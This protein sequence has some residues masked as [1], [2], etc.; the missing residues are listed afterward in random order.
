MAENGKGTGLWVG[1][2]RPEFGGNEALHS[3][4]DAGINK[5]GLALETRVTNGRNEGILAFESSS[6]GVDIFEIDMG[7]LDGCGKF[8]L[9]GFTGENRYVEFPRVD[10][11]I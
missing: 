9:G 3:G 7:D 1:Q 10:E 8:G 11:G 2:V 6:E 5:E 4:S